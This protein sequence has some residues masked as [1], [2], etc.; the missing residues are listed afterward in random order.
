[1]G[2]RCAGLAGSGSDRSTQP[3]GLCRAGVMPGLGPWAV[4]GR[5]GWSGGALAFDP[6]AV[7][8]PGL[9]V[10]EELKGEK[11]EPL[12]LASQGAGP[13]AGSEAGLEPRVH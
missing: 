5:S 2:V 9:V 1:M 7:E 13:I 6:F 4:S 12:L 10:A 8:H 11:V 3:G